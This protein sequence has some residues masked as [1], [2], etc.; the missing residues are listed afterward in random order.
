MPDFFP[1]NTDSKVSWT[2]ASYLIMNLSNLFQRAAN[3]Y[4]D[5]DYQRY[6]ECLLEIKHSTIQSFKPDERTNLSNQEATILET[7]S[8]L[9]NEK[10][11][12]NNPQLWMKINNK[13]YL[14]V[15]TYRTALM[16]CL[17]KHGYLNPDKQDR[18]KLVG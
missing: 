2:L 12:A 4:L 17:Q 18:T 6:F 16:D 15:N 7:I 13:I 5:R 14:L 1:D 3:A 11:R 9:S 8:Y 10:L